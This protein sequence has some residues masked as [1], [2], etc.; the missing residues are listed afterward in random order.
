MPA[1]P[2]FTLDS[3]RGGYN[4]EV[5]PNMLAPDEVTVAE[6]VEFFYSMLGERRLGSNQFPMSGSAIQADERVVY[7]THHFPDSDPFNNE[8]WVFSAVVGSHVTI[9]RGTSSLGW[10]TITPSDAVNANAPY[11]YQIRAISFDGMLFIAFKSGVDRL[12]VWDGTSLRRVGLAQPG[13]PSVADEGSGSFDTDRYYRVRYIAKSGSTIIRR[14]EPSDSV[15]FTPSGSGAGA[16]IT[17]PAAINEGE[18]DWEIEASY[19]GVTFYRIGTEPVATTTFD[20]ETPSSESYADVGP[21]S[22]PIGDYDLPGSVRFLGVDDDRVTMGSSFEQDALNS[23][24]QWTP[25]R[26]APGVGNDERIPANIDSFLDLDTSTGGGL[27]GISQAID[28][29][30]YAFKTARIYALYRTGVASSAYGS[31]TVSTQV[32]AIFDSIQEGKDQFGRGCIYFADLSAGPCRVG[33]SSGLVQIRGLRQFWERINLFATKA[34]ASVYYP[35]KRQMIWFIAADGTSFPSIGAKLQCSECRDVDGGDTKGCWSFITGRQAEA[36]TATTLYEVTQ[37]IFEHTV[38]VAKPVMGYTSPD[39]LLR[40]DVSSENSDNGT[41]YVARV[42]SRPLLSAG[43][44]N[45][46]ATTTAGIMASVKTAG[47][48]QVSCIRDFGKEKNYV[49][50][51]LTAEGS[52]EYILALFDNLVMSEAKAIQIELSDL[53]HQTDV[54]GRLY[55][56]QG[57]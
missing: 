52:E 45:K 57:S 30:W 32:G 35:A 50:C 8:I 13:V 46:W 41:E 17:K 39:F 24:V 9:S 34:M 3:F 22:E 47:R 7:V 48:V 53:E 10:S 6:N 2:D 55:T 19:D 33:V 4:D 40:M 28:G 38:I 11:V 25:V 21:L 23:R 29:R 26:G 44:L 36:L 12:H 43:L 16:Q 54:P 31:E 56:S 20:D 15:Q 18:T 1:P 27:Q 37:N 5:S 51:D 14:S 42:R 49:V